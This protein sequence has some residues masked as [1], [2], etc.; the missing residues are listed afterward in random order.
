MPAQKNLD[1][2]KERIKRERETYSDEEKEV[3]Q[4]QDRIERRMQEK[5]EKTMALKKNQ[6][7]LKL[8]QRVNLAMR[9]SDGSWKNPN[10]LLNG[11]G[12]YYWK[13]IIKNGPATVGCDKCA[14]MNNISGINPVC[15]NCGKPLTD[16]IKREK[17]NARAIVNAFHMREEIQAERIW[18]SQG[19]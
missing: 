6:K 2:V 13:E 19:E 18:E 8:R 17:A 7:K 9:G 10:L 4:R 3:L 5:H 15:S 11:H 16:E 1:K 12:L 14:I